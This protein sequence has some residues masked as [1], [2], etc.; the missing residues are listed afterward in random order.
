MNFVDDVDLVAGR[1]RRISHTVQQLAHVGDAGTAGRVELQHVRMPAFHDRLAVLT[2]RVELQARTFMVRTFIVER[3]CQQTRRGCFPHP[4]HTRQHE[5]VGDAV[6]FEGIAQGADHRLLADQV[7]E[8]FRAVFPR[9]HLIGFLIVRSAH[10]LLSEHGEGRVIAL[11][12]GLEITIIAHR[13]DNG[14]DSGVSAMAGPSF[15]RPLPVG[16][17]I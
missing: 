12:F 2:G 6:E 8:E 10:F 1:H 5:G 9:Q 3:P 16:G 7:R 17:S 4:A 13:A 14:R 11:V 15:S